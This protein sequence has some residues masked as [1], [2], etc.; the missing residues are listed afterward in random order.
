MG[1]LI[2]G[3]WVT[4]DLN[5]D[6]RGRFV[7]K[8]AA[9]RGLIGEPHHRAARGRYVLYASYACGWTHRTLIFRAL[10]GL[11]DVVPI[12]EVQPFMGDHGWTFASG[13]DWVNGAKH[14]YQVYQKAKPDYTGRATSPVLW[15]TETRSIVSNESADIIRSFDSCFST[16]SANDTSYFPPGMDARIDEMMRANYDT[17]NNGVYRAGFAGSQ[18]AHEEAVRDVFQRLSEL[19][20]LLGTQR[21]LLGRQLTAADWCLFP[22]LFRFDA[23]YHLHFK[24]NLKR[25]VDFPNLW[26]YTRELYQHRTVRE[27]CRLEDVKLHYYTSHE[28]IN[29]R[30]IIPL[31]PFLDFDEPHTRG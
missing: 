10:K 23:V 5:N 18:E 17:V 11:A 29:P 6:E 12:I 19:E 14:L 30:R 13:A 26:N 28:S 25:L 7:R 9:F 1:R 31:G 3:Q 24:C 21:Y 22:T 8:A 4:R 20:L 16:W 27:T 2:D 15:D